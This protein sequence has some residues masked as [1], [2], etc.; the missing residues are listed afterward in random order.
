[1]ATTATSGAWHP[2]SD[3]VTISTRTPCPDQV[4]SARRCASPAT[5]R[6]WHR[7]WPEAS[8]L[9]ADMRGGEL[10]AATLRLKSSAEG[11]TSNGYSGELFD[12][13]EARGDLGDAVVPQR[14][15]AL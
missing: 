5:S 3:G 14:A 4:D 1:M 13:G 15:H 12:R 10:V 7:T 6:A 2:P 11:A 8:L 9:A